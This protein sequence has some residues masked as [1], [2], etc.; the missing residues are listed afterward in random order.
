MA[1]I[2]RR[3]LHS[4]ILFYPNVMPLCFLETK[5]ETNI[6][7]SMNTYFSFLTVLYC[8]LSFEKHIHFFFWPPLY[9]L[10]SGEINTAVKLN[11][12]INGK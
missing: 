1:D 4:Q 6:K 11:D 10:N 8:S 12:R 5:N 9:I 2:H 3:H 7:A